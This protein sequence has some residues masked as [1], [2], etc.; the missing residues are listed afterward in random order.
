MTDGVMSCRIAVSVGKLAIYMGYY[1]FVLAD[2]V[3][4][5]GIF[6]ESLQYMKRHEKKCIFESLWLDSCSRD[7]NVVSFNQ[8]S[9]FL[10]QTLYSLFIVLG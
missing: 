6:Y 9:K 10:L 3:T 2:G 4:I 7:S 8:L 5:E 1:G